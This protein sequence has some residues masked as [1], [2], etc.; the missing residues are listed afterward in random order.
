MSQSYLILYM[1]NKHVQFNN[2]KEEIKYYHLKL[3]KM[4]TI[5]KVLGEKS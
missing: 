2:S 3:S 1:A 5:K 4:D